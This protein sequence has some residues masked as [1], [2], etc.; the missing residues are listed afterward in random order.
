MQ[1]ECD[2]NPLEVFVGF[3]LTCLAAV[4]SYTV[5]SAFYVKALFLDRCYSL[6]LMLLTSLTWLYCRSILLIDSVRNLCCKFHMEYWNARKSY[7]RKIRIFCIDEYYNWISP[8]INQKLESIWASL[9]SNNLVELSKLKFCKFDTI[10][11]NT[12]YH[13]LNLKFIVLIIT[14]TFGMVR[15][16]K[17]SQPLFIPLN[18][19]P[20]LST[21]IKWNGL[22]QVRY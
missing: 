16:L 13:M 14:H 9:V 4:V 17:D 10:L 22:Y 19:L 7:V 8:Q 15:I 11:Q 21:P 2:L 5:F 6:L 1:L 12:V 3:H 20:T 18:I